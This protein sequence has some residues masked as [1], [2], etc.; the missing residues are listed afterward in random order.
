[1]T[2]YAAGLDAYKG[3]RQAWAHDIGEV[4]RHDPNNPYYQ[5]ALGQK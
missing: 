1:M 4:L 5:W 3:D 2:F